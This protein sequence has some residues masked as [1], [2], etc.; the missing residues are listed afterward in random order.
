MR[1]TAEFRLVI[2]RAGGV[3][4]INV[5]RLIV[6]PYYKALLITRIHIL[7]LY[8]VPP[9]PDDRTSDMTIIDMQ[10]NGLSI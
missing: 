5:Q 3:S 1:S 4:Y 9:E 2:D 10:W 7:Q 8:A 6:P